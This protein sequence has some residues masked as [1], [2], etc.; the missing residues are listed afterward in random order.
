MLQQ[1]SQPQSVL[2][3]EEG[4]KKELPLAGQP[5][6]DKFCQRKGVGRTSGIMF[7]AA[8]AASSHPV[9]KQGL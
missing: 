9:Q 7:A 1:T 6:S 2:A 8:A 4:E 3:E 5:R